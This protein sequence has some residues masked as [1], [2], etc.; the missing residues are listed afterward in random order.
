MSVDDWDD[1]QDGYHP[2]PKIDIGGN[3][4]AFR[5]TA[6]TAGGRRKVWVFLFMLVAALFAG[7][8]ML[9]MYAAVDYP[10]RAWYFGMPPVA[11]FIFVGGFMA[12]FLIALPGLMKIGR[13]QATQELRVGDLG[14][15]IVQTIVP[16]QPPISTWSVHWRDL[17]GIKLR[18]RGVQ[19][20]YTGLVVTSRSGQTQFLRPSD[21]VPAEGQ[22]AVPASI[23]SALISD[24]KPGKRRALEQSDLVRALQQ[25]GQK[26]DDDVPRPQDRLAAIIGLSLG[27]G[28][29]VAALIFNYFE[30]R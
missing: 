30:T 16:N 12:S 27:I 17:A 9:A 25:R 20:P 22:A 14:M 11:T 8:A 18:Y 1:E 13:E 19:D 21:W 28:A 29:I 5:P 15:E 2:R 26:I 7:G 10:G 4:R 24:A 6:M 3:V 23:G